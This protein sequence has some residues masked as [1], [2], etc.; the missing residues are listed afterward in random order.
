VLLFGRGKKEKGNVT[1]R[2]LIKLAELRWQQ[3]SCVILYV[4]CCS[5]SAP[6]I[7]AN[8]AFSIPFARH[9][10]ALHAQYTYIHNHP[11]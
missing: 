2:V 6:T 8:E 5:S 7:R 9:I 11:K 4:V 10:G 3:T 1:Q